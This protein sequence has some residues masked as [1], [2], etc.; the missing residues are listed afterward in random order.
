MDVVCTV[1]H[2]GNLPKKRAGDLRVQD[3]LNDWTIKDGFMEGVIYL[4]DLNG[5]RRNSFECN[6]VPSEPELPSAAIFRLSLWHRQI[7]E[8]MARME[9]KM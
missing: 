4:A 5:M 6:I 9:N 8:R 7:F 3:K 2:S 1:G